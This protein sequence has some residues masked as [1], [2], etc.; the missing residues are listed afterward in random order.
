MTRGGAYVVLQ[1]SNGKCVNLREHGVNRVVCPALRCLVRFSAFE[2]EDI[3]SCP[4][5]ID[6]HEA[7]GCCCGN[8]HCDHVRPVC[9]RSRL[10]RPYI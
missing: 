8:G 9:G 2:E 1:Y 7:V 10:R 3:G 6:N 5:L 4:G